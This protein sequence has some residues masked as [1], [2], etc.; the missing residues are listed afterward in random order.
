M[1][2]ADKAKKAKL[3]CRTVKRLFPARVWRRLERLCMC[4]CKT[5]FLQSCIYGSSSVLVSKL[6]DWESFTEKLGID[7]MIFTL[8]KSK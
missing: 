8:S 6:V 7:K 1:F 3:M 2:T 5:G 4:C